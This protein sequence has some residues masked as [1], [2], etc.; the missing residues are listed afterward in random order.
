MTDLEKAA[1]QA[2]DAL[3]KQQADDET[4]NPSF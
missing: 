2:L 1:R 3:A 4:G